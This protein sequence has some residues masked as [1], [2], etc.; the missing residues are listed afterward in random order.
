MIHDASAQNK[1]K[2]ALKLN[3]RSL[4]LVDKSLSDVTIETEKTLKL[5]LSEKE[6]YYAFE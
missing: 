3:G 5:R 6:E 1:P 2:E 4:V